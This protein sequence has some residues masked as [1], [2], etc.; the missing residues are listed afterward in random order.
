M[1]FVEGFLCRPHAA[2][3]ERM[4]P[5]PPPPI[6]ASIV[7]ALALVPCVGGQTHTG[8]PTVNP[9][10]VFVFAQTEDGTVLLL[11]KV[12]HPAGDAT[13]NSSHAPAHLED[14]VVGFESQAPP[15]QVLRQEPPRDAHLFRRQLQRGRCRPADLCIACSGITLKG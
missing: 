3:S 12:A 5:L 8:R 14:A 13:T 10:K 1:V 15:H 7:R 11:V 2:R 9:Q 6:L 4:A